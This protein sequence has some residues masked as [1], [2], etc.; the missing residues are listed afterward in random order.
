MESGQVGIELILVLILMLA[1]FVVSVFAVMQ[2][3]L[4]AE[5]FEKQ[6]DNTAECTRLS[7]AI[8]SLYASGNGAR[9]LG[10]T[11]KNVLVDANY[12]LVTN[13][14]SGKPYEAYCRHS[15]D[16]NTASFSFT[17]SF[18]LKNSRGAIAYEKK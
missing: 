8:S 6:L 5:Y 13:I 3:N 7:A 15:A 17:G 18:L 11:D 12:V 9:F 14:G 1:I 16:L 10:A 2:K 4:Q